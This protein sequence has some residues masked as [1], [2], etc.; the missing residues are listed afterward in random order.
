MD[1]QS[2][3]IFPF[4]KVGSSPICWKNSWGSLSFNGCSAWLNSSRSRSSPRNNHRKPSFCQSQRIYYYPQTTT[5]AWRH[6]RRR[7]SSRRKSLGCVGNT[8]NSRIGWTYSTPWNQW[9]HFR[10]KNKCRWGSTETGMAAL[11]RGFWVKNDVLLQ[12]DAVD[13]VV[14]AVR[15]RWIDIWCQV[16]GI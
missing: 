6:R 11:L 3:I 5:V 7:P 4:W 15:R 8:G 16:G 2:K 10:C 14:V 1:S 13:V 12:G 9:M